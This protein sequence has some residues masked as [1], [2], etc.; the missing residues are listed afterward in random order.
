ML[1]AGFRPGV[2]GAK[3]ERKGDHV[4]GKRSTGAAGRARR[5]LLGEGNPSAPRRGKTEFVMSK[6]DNVQST[7][8]S[9]I[10]KLPAYVD[11]SSPKL[12]ALRKCARSF[13]ESCGSFGLD[14]G[15]AE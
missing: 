11:F 14:A 4:D 5:G 6:S 12:G 9:S 2:R 15:G 3:S 10:S 1:H 13:P 8:L 7:D